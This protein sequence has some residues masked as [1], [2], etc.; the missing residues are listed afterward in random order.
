[1]TR[2]LLFGAYSPARICFP[3][4][5]VALAL[6]SAGCLL[7]N[8]RPSLPRNFPRDAAMRGKNPIIIVPGVLGSALI[9]RET[10]EKAWPSLSDSADDTIEMPI[11]GATLAD[12]SDRLIAGDMLETAKFSSLLPEISVYDGLV[13][14]LQRFGAY[15]RGSFENPPDNGAED[16]FYVFAYDWRRDNVESARL[17]G[18]RIR[19]LKEK[20]GRPDLRFDIIAHSMGGL[21]AR[22]YAMYGE[23]DLPAGAPPEITWAGAR[24]LRRLILMGTPNAGSM[25]AFRTVTLGYSITGTNQVRLA[26]LEPLGVNAVYTIPSLYQLLPRNGNTRFLDEKLAPLH[27]NLYDIEVWRKYKWSAVFNVRLD[28]KR[29]KELEKAGGQDAVFRE[30]SRISDERAVFLRRALARAAAFH[31]AI[32]QPATLPDSLRL[33][34]Y[35]G[36]CEDTLDAAV[37]IPD[38]KKDAPVTLF[39]PTRALGSRGFRNQAYRMMFA[40]GDTRVTRRSLFGLSFEPEQLSGQMKEAGN[41]DGARAMKQEPFQA[42]FDCEI[43]GDLPLNERVLNNLLTMLLGNRY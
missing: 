8:T 41:G 16:T 11:G 13:A 34:L 36:D 28:R 42:L 31:Q 43:H 18:R 37:I 3:P 15:Q 32:D 26:W 19:E 25:D 33:Y 29:K 22:Y 1:M 17:L 4:L 23:E 27:L 20:L 40:P 39:R 24:H 14:A 30:M 7:G 10:G 9:N 5:L 2:E 38:S 12:N 6:L 35:G 21:V